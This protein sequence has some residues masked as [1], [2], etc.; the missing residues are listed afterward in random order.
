MHYVFCRF[1]DHPN[2]RKSLVLYLES[3]NAQKP[4]IKYITNDMTM[5]GTEKELTD[6]QGT[7]HHT[8]QCF[9]IAGKKKDV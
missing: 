1:G 9:L 2:I 4:T 7:Q 3:E 8:E 5:G 6:E